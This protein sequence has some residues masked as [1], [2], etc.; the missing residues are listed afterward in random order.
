MQFDRLNRRQFV[1]LLG[2]AAAAWPLAARAQQLTMPLIGYLHPGSPKGEEFAVLAFRNGLS[3]TGYIEGRNVA[4]EYRWADNDID[5]LPGLVADLVRR[6]VAVIA[7]PG[8]LVAALAAKA[9]TTTIPIVFSGGI[10]PVAAGLVASFNRPGGNVTGYVQMST[11]LMPKRLGIIHDLLPNAM[12]F[13]VLLNPNNP[14][15]EATIAGLRT[16]ASTIRLQIEV[17]YASA[18]RDIDTAYSAFVQNR[19]EGLLVGP[20]A[21]FINRRTQL[22]LL[23]ASHRLPA[24]YSA[25]NYAESGGLMSYGVEPDAQFR[26]TGKYTGRILRGEKPADLPVMQAA[27]FEFTINL[28]AA[29]VLGIEVPNSLQLLADEVID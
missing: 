1:T 17:H 11:E 29:K 26:E 14:N 28:Q 4:I 21:P 12:R 23:A 18:A 25:R 13:A 3:E 20:G 24:I 10:D 16:A 2:G 9:A 15:I 19:V 7:T 27:K 6:Q 22:A 5:R 8:S